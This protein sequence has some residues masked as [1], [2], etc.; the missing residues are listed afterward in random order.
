MDVY[1]TKRVRSAMKR[2]FQHVFVDWTVSEILVKKLNLLT[3][4]IDGTEVPVYTKT[5]F[6]FCI[7]PYTKRSSRKGGKKTVQ[8]QPSESLIGLYRVSSI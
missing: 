7:S 4:I 8:T 2:S 5:K 3:L 6:L 1:A